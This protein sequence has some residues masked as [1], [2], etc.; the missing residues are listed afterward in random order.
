MLASIDLKRIDENWN[1]MITTKMYIV[2]ALYR[3]RY[4]VSPWVE[5][6]DIKGSRSD[7]DFLL[8]ITTREY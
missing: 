4:C 1:I 2:N 5:M 6:L 7:F 8:N 3:I